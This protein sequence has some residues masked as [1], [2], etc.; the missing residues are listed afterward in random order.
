MTGRTGL[1]V[2]VACAA[3]A[4]LICAWF[5]V[6]IRQAHDT[7]R[8]TALLD[9][10]AKVAPS[11]GAEIRSALDGADTLNPDRTVDIL[12]AQL[13]LASGQHRPAQR[14]LESVIRSEPE[15]IKAWLLLAASAGG[16]E[17]LYVA[18]L[19][20]ARALEPRIPGVS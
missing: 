17:S 11:Q 10:H 18:A 19:R 5:A 1:L 6:G 9:D 8:A 2:R 15:N 16:D 3:A 20:H 7:D 4:L 14:R 13:W 12:R